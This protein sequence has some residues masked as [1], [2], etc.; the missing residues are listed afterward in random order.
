MYI[1]I[2]I[3]TI[4][5]YI[6]IYIH[7][8][9]YRSKEH[10]PTETT[11]GKARG[12]P[13]IS[14][15]QIHLFKVSRLISESLVAFAKKNAWKEK[16]TSTPFFS[17]SRLFFHW[18]SHEPRGQFGIPWTI[19]SL[20]SQHPFLGKTFCEKKHRYQPVRNDIAWTSLVNWGYLFHIVLHCARRM[21]PQLCS[22]Y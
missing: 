5:T 16:N 4:Y 1:H 18:C 22:S 11:S 12:K 14:G 6:T 8:Y 19:I 10:I 9:I 7:I 13:N 15:S 21:V 20:I 2:Y 17:V 3:C